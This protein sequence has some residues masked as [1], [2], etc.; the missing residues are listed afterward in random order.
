MLSQI[1]RLVQITKNKAAFRFKNVELFCFLC[2]IGWLGFQCLLYEHKKW[3]VFWL[4]THK[5]KI[6]IKPA[7]QSHRSNEV[8]NYNHYITLKA[9]LYIMYWV[10]NP[11]LL[12]KTLLFRD[13]FYNSFPSIY[14]CFVLISLC[15]V[16]KSNC[17]IEYI[18]NFSK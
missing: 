5:A 3:F 6:H 8:L 9:C 15:T 18:R 12:L 2:L 14:L 4:Q 10:Y 16:L 13:L 17:L 7:Q 11:Y 1:L